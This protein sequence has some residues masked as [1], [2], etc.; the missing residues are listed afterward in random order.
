VQR[1]PSA[2]PRSACS[3]TCRV[4]ARS[5]R[6]AFC[7]CLVGLSVAGNLVGDGLYQ[8]V[9]ATSDICTS[10]PL[11]HCM[12]EQHLELPQSGFSHVRVP[13]ELGLML[14]TQRQ[15][16]QRSIVLAVY[17]KPVAIPNALPSLTHARFIK[18]WPINSMP[19]ASG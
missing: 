3:R 4:R 13:L 8:R 2:R 14:K 1:S 9:C 10:G 16:P 19:K 15:F 5:P 18:Q 12:W 17:K 7:A 6:R 11:A